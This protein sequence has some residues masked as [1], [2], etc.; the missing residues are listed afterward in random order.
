M[1]G[2]R[3]YIDFK[4]FSHFYPMASICLIL[5]LALVFR[6]GRHGDGWLVTDDT[7]SQGYATNLVPIE[8]PIAAFRHK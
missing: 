8:V 4:L 6:C 5:H 2:K 1:S 3:R 7:D